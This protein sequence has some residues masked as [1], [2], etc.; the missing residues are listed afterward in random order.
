M[1]SSGRTVVE[2]LDPE[3][4]RWLDL[5]G[6][7][8][9]V[10]EADYIFAASKKPWLTVCSGVIG[11][12]LGTRR[13]FINRQV[14]KDY[15]EDRP[16]EEMAAFLAAGFREYGSAAGADWAGLMTAARVG[17]ACWVRLSQQGRSVTVIVTAGVNNACVAG[18]TPCCGMEGVVSPPGTINIMAFFS[19]A[20]SPG[21]V[22]NAVQT[23]TEAK[24]RTLREMRILCPYTGAYA[25]GTNTD[26]MVIAAPDLPPLQPYAGPGTLPGYL[27]ALGVRKALRR[28]LE[29]YLKWQKNSG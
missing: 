28:A 29:R 22:V 11:G 5:G 17:D 1:V 6:G 24:A 12:G 27:L 19:H 20:L 8:G 15:D 16:E 14:D 23:A 26:A 13:Y 4:G 21:A 7:L 9:A 2:Y 25:T 10:L 18:L 3:P